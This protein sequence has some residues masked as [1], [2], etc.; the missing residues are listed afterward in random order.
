LVA[1]VD[2]EVSASIGNGWVTVPGYPTDEDAAALERGVAEGSSPC[3][4]RVVTTSA[5]RPMLWS[6]PK[7]SATSCS[8]RFVSSR[9][10]SVTLPDDLSTPYGVMLFYRGHW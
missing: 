1:I 6:C 9:W 3:S 2:L 10:S 4:M 8:R 7:S 5:R